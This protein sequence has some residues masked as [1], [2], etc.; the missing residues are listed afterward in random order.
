MLISSL[1]CAFDVKL[2]NLLHYHGRF[3]HNIIQLSSC[4]SVSFHILGPNEG[5]ASG[6][7]DAAYSDS[8]PQNTRRYRS[9]R[10]S[11]T[12]KPGILR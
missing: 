3:F 6:S 2:F 12:V 1:D 5:I 8:E 4:K 10:L 11:K 9:V 7:V